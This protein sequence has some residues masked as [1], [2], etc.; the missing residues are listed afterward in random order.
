MG[1]DDDDDDALSKSSSSSSSLMM[2][3]CPRP[4][5]RRLPSSR[6][7]RPRHDDVALKPLEADLA[8]LPVSVGPE[9]GLVTHGVRGPK[10]LI[11]MM[12]MMMMMMATMMMLLM[13]MILMMTMVMVRWPLDSP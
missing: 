3:R 9:D 6:Y 2:M 4:H 7:H 12:V 1:H 5:R 8:S 11:M 10:R 13:T